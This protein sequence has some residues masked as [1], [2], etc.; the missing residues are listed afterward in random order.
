MGSVH[1]ASSGFKCRIVP[2]VTARL[3]SGENAGLLSNRSR[4]GTGL[5]QSEQVRPQRCGRCRRR[6]AVQAAVSTPPAQDSPVTCPRGS[7]WQV[8]IYFVALETCKHSL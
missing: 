8:G 3:G 4:S 1:A 7:H 5:G 6:T 2:S